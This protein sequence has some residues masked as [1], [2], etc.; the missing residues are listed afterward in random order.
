MTGS[1]VDEGRVGR[2]VPRT[3]EDVNENFKRETIEMSGKRIF[4]VLRKPLMKYNYRE[5]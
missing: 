2:F 3:E 5:D 1:G 4:K